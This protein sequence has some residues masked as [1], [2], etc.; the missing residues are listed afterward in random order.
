[1][2]F[3][4][5]VKTTKEVLLKMHRKQAIA[6]R[7]PRGGTML[8]STRRP[9]LNTSGRVKEAARMWEMCGCAH[10]RCDGRTGKVKDLEKKTC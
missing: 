10:Q 5:V 2:W 4:A 8:S 6:R 1:M 9:A 3:R 7:L